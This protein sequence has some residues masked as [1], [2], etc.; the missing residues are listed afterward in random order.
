MTVYLESNF[1]LEITL[2]QEQ[3][4]AAEAILDRAE[5]RE[6]V[7]AIPWLALAEPFAT[8]M[9]RSQDRNTLVDLMNRQ[10]SGLRRSPMLGG[11]A[12]D[13]ENALNRLAPIN[14][15]VTDNLLQTT[16]RILDVAT[17]LS[18]N[19]AVFRQAMAYRTLHGLSPQDAM[20][21]ASVVGDLASNDSSGPHH[22]VTRDLDFQVK[23]IENE[24]RTNNCDLL[25]SF[26][27]MAVLLGRPHTD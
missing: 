14:R 2:G 8:I 21:Y 9:K 22:F 26:T 17:V 16:E 10:L 27:E 25:S 5:R 15:E 20:V 7:L 23:D 6:A 13:M 12:R 24:L 1:V 11:A 19:G 4:S 18:V 3:A